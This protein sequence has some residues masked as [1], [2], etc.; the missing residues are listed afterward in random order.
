MKV[1]C[2]RCN[3]VFNVETLDD[4]GLVE[5]IP[6]QSL[7]EAKASGPPAGGPGRAPGSSEARFEMGLGFAVDG[8]HCGAFGPSLRGLASPV[9]LLRS[10][11]LTG[12][13]PGRSRSWIRRARARWGGGKRLSM[14]RRRLSA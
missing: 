8:R 5:A 6:V 7:D 3:R 1:K 4:G 12:G 14:R 13:T 2:P 10:M 11:D 9:W